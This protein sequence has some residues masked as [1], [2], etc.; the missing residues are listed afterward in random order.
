[1]VDYSIINK[2]TEKYGKYQSASNGEYRFNCPFCLKRTG[3]PDIKQ[4]MY[5]N[6]N[7]VLK[8]Y[9]DIVG[10]WN[11]YRC[12]AR[13]PLN[14]LVQISDTVSTSLVDWKKKVINRL[15]NNIQSIDNE[16]LKVRIELPIDY[17]SMIENTDACGYLLNRDITN[18]QIDQYGIGMGTE[19]LRDINSKSERR[20]YAGLGRIVFPD[21]DDN[22]LVYWVART[23]VN[24][25][26]KYKNPHGVDS[27]D[28]LYNLHRALQYKDVIITEGVISAIKAG[29]NAVATYGKNVT[30]EQLMLLIS[31]DFDRYYVALDGDTIKKRQ[32]TKK[33][34]E[35]IQL[36]KRLQNEGCSV[37]VVNLPY[38][39][40]PA[41]VDNFKLYLD[42]AIEFNFRSMLELMMQ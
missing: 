28:K 42:N 6:P 4:H 22:G 18:R 34:P 7:R 25:S 13:G 38:D 29:V 41:S 32:G 8:E 5:V 31:G 40:D 39:E 16:D 11:C 17:I 27:G 9:P 21:Y 15:N 14:S 20:R 23:Y 3:R 37:F 24:H 26:I 19:D 35:S 12:G 30:H 2:L 33:L 10:W 36:A 1:M